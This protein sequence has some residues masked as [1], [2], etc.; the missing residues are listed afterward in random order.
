LAKIYVK[1]G[2]K[3]LARKE[4]DELTQLGDKFP[5]HDE[6]AFLLTGL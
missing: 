2:K 6:V 5:A 1:G 3:D 4:L